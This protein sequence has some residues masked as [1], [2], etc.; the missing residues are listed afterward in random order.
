MSHIRIWGD[1]PTSD[2]IKRLVVSDLMTRW[3]LGSSHHIEKMQ[4][5]TVPE[6]DHNN[7][8]AVDKKLLQN[9]GHHWKCFEYIIE[10]VET[11]KYML[12]GYWDRAWESIDVLS[13]QDFEENCVEFFTA[14]GCFNPHANLKEHPDIKYTPLNKI[15]W[16]PNTETEINKLYQEGVANRIV[17][18]KLHVRMM[19][20]GYG[21]RS[22]LVHDDRFVALTGP[23]TRPEQ[24][25]QE[26]HR[27]WI[28]MD[29]YSVSG[30]SM[31]LIESMG[32]G[33]VVLSPRFPQRH[34]HE[35]IPDYHYV[36]VPFDGDHIPFG[37]FGENPVATAA[38]SK[39]FKELADSYIDTFEK[40]K[41]E[42]DKIQYIS[43]N[44]RKY[45]LENCTR[46]NYVNNLEK[47]LDLNK[48]L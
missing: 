12:L 19:N 40:L 48:I 3:E 13:R 31:R 23:K 25:A 38:D 18:E 41:Q 1:W 29:T 39:I 5:R 45:Y 37:P 9:H 33:T 24:H 22:H 26:L 30:V 46:F 7:I 11:R 4:Y 44:A 43:T 16:E 36:E 28:N 34:Q 17:P 35:I 21:F 32:L 15:P 47:L 27:H 20:N 42:P 2:D 10:N 6:S 14:Q 8:P